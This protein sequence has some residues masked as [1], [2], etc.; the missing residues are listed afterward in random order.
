[1][2]FLQCSIYILQR[3]NKLGEKMFSPDDYTKNFENIFKVT[4]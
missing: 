3:R 1:M 4:I 2:T